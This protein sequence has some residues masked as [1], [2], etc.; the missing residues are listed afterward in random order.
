MNRIFAISIGLASLCVSVATIQAQEKTPVAVDILADYSVATNPFSQNWEIALGIQG[1]SFYSNQENF[2]GYEQSP[3]KSFR[4]QLGISLSVGKWFTPEIG[5]RTKLSGFWGRSV[6]RQD[7]DYNSVKYFSLHEDVLINISNLIWNYDENRKWGVSPYIGV[8]MARNFSYNK[9]PITMNLGIVG[10]YRIAEKLKVYTDFGFTLCG[11]EFDEQP[12]K[13]TSNIINSRDRWL[14]LEIGAILELGQNKWKHVPDMDNVEVVPWFETEREL[15]RTRRKV[16]DLTQ[17]VDFSR[18]QKPAEEPAPQTIIKSNSPEVSIFFE[19]GS[20]ELNHRGQLEN[21]K[22]LVETAKK[23]NRTIV[24][25]GFADSQTGNEQLNERL[26]ARRADTIVKEIMEM[27][28]DAQQIKIVI[29]GGVN[30]L[31]PVPANRRVVV[32]LGE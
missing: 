9:T 20:S 2:R 10:T 28:I 17:Q 8:G 21:I 27:G 24:V 29:G 11:G 22:E 30:T 32:S 14:A 13:L 1:L 5:L 19:I 12:L 31:N 4:N 25:A 7:K 16:R 15:K 3:F 18:T 23:E 6:S 26:S